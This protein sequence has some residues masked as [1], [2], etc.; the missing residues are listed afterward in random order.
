MKQLINTKT[1]FSII[2]NDNKRE[3]IYI[4]HNCVKITHMRAEA[5][6]RHIV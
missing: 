4:F 2:C 1:L 3:D 5:Y 6:M